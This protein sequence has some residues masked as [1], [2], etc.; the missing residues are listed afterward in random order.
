MVFARGFLHSSVDKHLPATWETWVQFRGQEDPL[1]KEM[2]TH[3]SIL[4]WRVPWT[5]EPGGLQ[6]C[7]CIYWNEH[8]CFV[9]YLID[10]VVVQLLSHVQL[11]DTPWTAAHYPSLS[12]RICANSCPLSQRCH[13]TVSSFVA[14]FSHCPQSFPA[15]GSFP[16]SLLIGASQSALPVNIQDW[17]P[18]GLIGLISLLFMEL[19]RVF[20]STT[21]WKHQ[22][23]G[24]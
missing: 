23:F 16:M 22:S 14:P 21:V 15:P 3:L 24:T 17:F 6:F 9:I 18:L 19:S 12:P 2:A 4:A 5:E 20:S 11:F 10:G 8:V 1:E 7:F 13:P